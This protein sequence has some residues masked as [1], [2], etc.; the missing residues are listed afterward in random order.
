MAHTMR[1]L[2]NN[3]AKQ[4]L[5]RRRKGDPLSMTPGAIYQRRYRA[6]LKKPINEAVKS[7]DKRK[8]EV[9]LATIKR[10]FET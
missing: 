8:K 2:I 1:Q 7:L 4:R 10:A 5:G 3:E 6:K 9:R